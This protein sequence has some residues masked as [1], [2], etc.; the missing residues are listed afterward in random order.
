MSSRPASTSISQLWQV[1]LLAVSVGLFG[2]AAYLLWDPKP[3]PTVEQQ[4]LVA[5]QFLDAERPE[6]AVEQLN[7]IIKLDKLTPEQGE[8]LRSLQATLLH[9]P[10]LGPDEIVLLPRARRYLAGAGA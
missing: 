10:A 3:G 1:P 6:A 8:T 2:Y 9:R 4:L 7:R 5:R